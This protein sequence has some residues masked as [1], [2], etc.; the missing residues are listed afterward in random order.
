VTKNR[1]TSFFSNGRC[2]FFAAL[3]LNVAKHDE[4]AFRGGEACATEAN[5]L[6]RACND[7]DSSP[8]TIAHFAR[9]HY[10]G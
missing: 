9:L 6:R 4:R 5:P 7:D 1:L 10:D 2:G 3:P 8:K